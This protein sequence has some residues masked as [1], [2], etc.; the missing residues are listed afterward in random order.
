M[1]DA[2]GRQELLAHLKL[3]FNRWWDTGVGPAVPA[4][5][6]ADLGYIASQL[7]AGKALTI[8]GPRQTGKTTLVRQL[9]NSRLKVQEP[10][11]ILYVQFDD[12]KLLDLTRSPLQ[13][14][15]DVYE[16]FVLK[17]KLEL[18]QRP[19]CLFLDEVQRLPSWQQVVK[20]LL[21][22]NPKLNIVAT[23]SST[24]LIKQSGQE[25]LPWRQILYELYPLKFRE[26]VALLLHESPVQG[27]LDR[28][29]LTGIARSLREA[30]RL[31]AQERDLGIFEKAVHAALFDLAGVAP[32]LASFATKYL[33][34]GGYP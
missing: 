4:F 28:K 16:E 31:S 12:R 9:I 23:G 3:R 6:R 7:D 30:F 15:L 22:A 32:Q 8:V 21:A 29:L 13:D 2:S 34:V 18:T 26:F 17:E 19:V 24:W 27:K 5:Q 11:T 20:D 14:V 25:T 33:R 10:E 1:L